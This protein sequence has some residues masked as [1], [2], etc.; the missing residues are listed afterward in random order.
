[1]IKKRSNPAASCPL[2]SGRGAINGA[3]GSFFI[4]GNLGFTKLDSGI[5]LSSVWN[6]P[7]ATRVVWITMLG[8]ANYEGKVLC[9]RS[10]LYRSANIPGDDNNEAFNEAILCLESPD[11]DSRSGEHEGR[12]IEKIDG[13]WLVLNYKKYRQW[14]YSSSKEAIKKR[15]QRGR[16][17]T[18]G[19]MSLNSGDISAS[20]LNKILSYL[21]EK[22]GKNFKKDSDGAIAARIK[23]GATFEDFK[24]IIDI[25]VAKWKGKSWP[26]KKDPYRTC[27]G[28]DYLR[29]STL[30]SKGHFDEYLNECPSRNTQSDIDEQLEREIAER[31]RDHKK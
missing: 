18:P 20:V 17:G 3:P 7:L 22:T 28:D 13:G 31:E 30:F 10:G 27:F 4:G 6:E 26:D 21:N 16:L 19:D 9:S 15:K 14:S 5:V 1:M 12:R 29:P 2:P 23:D 24:K 8:M 11:P 25:K